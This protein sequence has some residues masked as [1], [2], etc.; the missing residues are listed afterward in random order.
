MFVTKSRNKSKVVG[1][2]TYIEF[3]INFGHM[4]CQDQSPVSG[5]DG[6]DMGWTALDSKR[7]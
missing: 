5:S 7:K 2:V 6:R 1:K 3:Q 4:M